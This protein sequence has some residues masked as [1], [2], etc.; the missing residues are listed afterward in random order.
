MMRRCRSIKGIS[1]DGAYDT[2]GYHRAIR[3][4]KAN[5]LIPPRDGAAFRYTKCQFVHYDIGPLV[6][7]VIFEYAKKISLHFQ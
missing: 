6:I 2:R 5:P 3:V 4:K 7:Q 1:G